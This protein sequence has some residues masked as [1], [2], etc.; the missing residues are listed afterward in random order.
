[1]AAPP[2]PWTYGYQED[3][4][5]LNSVVVRP[6]VPV[7]VVGV[8]T[9]PPVLALVDSGSEHVLAAP[10]L[11]TAVGVDPD[12]AHRTLDLGIGGDTVL[13]RFLDLGLRLHAPDGTDEDVVEWEAEVGFV[14]RWRPTWPVI[15]GQVGFLDRF[16]V[17][18]SRQ[19]RRIAIEDWDAFDRRFSP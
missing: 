19:A 3:G 12:D 16:T 13:V 5:R 7:S 1:M 6:V 2:F 14:H 18:M 17:T 15:L 11:A 4:P 9:S 8:E 10:W